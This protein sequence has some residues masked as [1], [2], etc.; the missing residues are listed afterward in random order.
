LAKKRAQ[1]NCLHS[2]Q[3]TTLKHLRTLHKI[4][5]VLVVATRASAKR[6]YEYY[7]FGSKKQLHYSNLEDKI[8]LLLLVKFHTAELLSVSMCTRTITICNDHNNDIFILIP[9]NVLVL[10]P[11]VE[12]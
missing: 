7:S 8:A 5:H 9:P 3:I 4:L 10:T 2:G 11:S 1:I 12:V 6:H